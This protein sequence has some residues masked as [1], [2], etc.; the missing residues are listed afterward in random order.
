[1]EEAG[2]EEIPIDDLMRA[3][4]RTEDYQDA[5]DKV[6]YAAILFCIPVG[7]VCVHTEQQGVKGFCTSA[8]AWG[9]STEPAERALAHAFPTHWCV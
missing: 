2:E 4:P 8:A 1:M 3:F 7:A 6:G 5:K 9:S